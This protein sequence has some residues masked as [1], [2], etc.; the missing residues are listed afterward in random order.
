MILKLQNL[1]RY[2][3][4]AVLVAM[5][6]G[7]LSA[8]GLLVVGGTAATTALVATDRR[9]AGEQV[10][11]RAIVMKAGAENRKLLEGKEGRINSSSYAGAVLLTGD[12]PTEADKLEAGKRVADIEK[13]T[14][15]YNELRVG[16]PTEL[17]V[18]S[19]DSWLF[20]RVST[21]LINTKGVPSRTISVSTERGVIYLMGKVT[22]DE[23][24][25]AALAASGVP[26]VNRVVKL[27]HYVSAESLLLDNNKP[28]SQPATE[29]Q[30]PPTMEPTQSQVE[31]MPV[32]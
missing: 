22:H 24:E 14:R 11:D 1:R 3:M 17:S 27:F 32:Q 31:V 7:A 19:N 15:V 21:A 13:V 23:G 20:T 5:T 16:P 9:T 29:P 12:V 25:R 30:A 18:R 8:C 6:T 10:E 2:T 26:G 28:A 4:M